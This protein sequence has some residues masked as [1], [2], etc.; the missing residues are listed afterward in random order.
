MVDAQSVINCTVVGQ[1]TSELRRLTAV[2]YHRDRQALSRARF[3]RADQLATADTHL[4][5]E[6]TL[7][8]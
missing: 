2:V 4:F 8:S 5:V 6:L 1:L 7:Q 3:R